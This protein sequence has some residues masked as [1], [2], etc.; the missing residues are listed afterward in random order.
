MSEPDIVPVV[1]ADAV[2]RL[3]R[4]EYDALVG[5]GVFEGEKVELLHGVIVR[6]SPQGSEHFWSS[7]RIGQ[8]LIRA[9]GDRAF[10]AIQSSFAAS[11]E[12]EPEPDV[13]VYSPG[14]YYDR[15][16]SEALLLVEVAKTSLRTDRGVKA[17]LYASVGVPE[18]WLV[19][20]AHAVVTVYRRPVGDEYVEVSSVGLDGEVSPAAFPDVRIPTRTF[21]R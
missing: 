2:R 7:N 1:G 6:M 10:V 16:P 12:S 14:D 5:L 13:G 11:D 21:L 19:D 3:R 17:P 20:L 8:A 9:L 4:S 15:L 18:Y